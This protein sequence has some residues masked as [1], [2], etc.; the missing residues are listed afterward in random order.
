MVGL[1]SARLPAD[2]RRLILID[3]PPLPAREIRA[4]LYAGQVVLA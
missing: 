4:P 1:L 3:G 2:P